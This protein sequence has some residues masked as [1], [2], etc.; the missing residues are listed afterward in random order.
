METILIVVIHILG[1]LL[2]F[3]GFCLEFKTL[4]FKTLEFKTFEMGVICENEAKKLYLTILG[5]VY[6]IIGLILIQIQALPL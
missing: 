3:S 1:Y 2:I 6:I 5:F 4:E